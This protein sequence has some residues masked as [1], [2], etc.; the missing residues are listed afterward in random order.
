MRTM[1]VSRHKGPVFF[2][3]KN[4][5]FIGF[6]MLYA[7]IDLSTTVG[8]MTAHNGYNGHRCCSRSPLQPI[9]QSSSKYKAHGSAGVLGIS[10][11]IDKLLISKIS[12]D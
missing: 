5:P 1:C 4:E 10:V 12:L 8:N 7:N 6:L 3:D 11:H 9:L 2:S